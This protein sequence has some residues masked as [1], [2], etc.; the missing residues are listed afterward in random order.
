MLISHYY[1]VV[2]NVIGTRAV[3]VAATWE[4]VIWSDHGVIY[5]RLRKD[6]QNSQRFIRTHF[7]ISLSSSAYYKFCF[8]RTQW[9]VSL[10]CWRHLLLLSKS[11][12]SSHH[13]LL[14]AK[15]AN[16]V[17]LPLYLCLP[18]HQLWPNLPRVKVCYFTFPVILAIM[19]WTDGRYLQ[20]KVT[21][22]LKF[23]VTLLLIFASWMVI[24]LSG[25]GFS[26]GMLFVWKSVVS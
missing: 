21:L 9:Q 18:F 13:Q 12:K 23:I 15:R 22:A 6:I 10:L 19:I 3:L 4:L 8:T 2:I 7:S 17:S 20:R 16:A 11:Q 24:K 5:F 26:V 1:F 25:K 14:P